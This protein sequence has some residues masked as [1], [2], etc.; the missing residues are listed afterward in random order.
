MGAR[1]YVP[2]LGRF[3]QVDPIE[4]GVDNDYVWP[5]DPSERTTRADFP[6]GLEPG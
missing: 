6:S 5:T 4:G 1:P 2:A 3:L